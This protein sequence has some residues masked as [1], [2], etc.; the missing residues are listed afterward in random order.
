MVQAK[1]SLKFLCIA[2]ALT[3]EENKGTT[4]AD[5]FSK[6]FAIRALSRTMRIQKWI[7]ALL[8]S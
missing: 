6:I 8:Q 7:Y 3:T 4:G 1:I 2:G 5:L